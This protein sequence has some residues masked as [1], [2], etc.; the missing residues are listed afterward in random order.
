MPSKN[1]QE[2]P[3]EDVV[4]PERDPD[5]DQ[6]DLA[7]ANPQRQRVD[8]IGGT[9]EDQIRAEV[10]RD[11]DPKDGAP[12]HEL[13]AE[14]HFPAKDSISQARLP[15]ARSQGIICPGILPDRVVSCKRTGLYGTWD[16]CHKFVVP[17]SRK[18]AARPPKGGIT[19]RALPIARNVLPGY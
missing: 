9:S 3:K 17:G 2:I 18:S 11:Q 4:P 1:D 6:A 8:E 19:N 12:K 14:V 16:K 7:N 10:A 5:R 15:A 13:A